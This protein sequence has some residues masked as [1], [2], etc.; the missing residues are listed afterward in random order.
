MAAFIPV[1]Y[2]LKPDIYSISLRIFRDDLLLQ[3]ENIPLTVIPKQFVTQYLKVTAAQNAIR[4]SDR[5]Y[6]DWAAFARGR[7]VTAPIPLWE[8]DFIMP[9]AGKITTEFGLTRYVNNANPTRH[10]GLD[11]A[12][13]KGTPV[14]ATNSGRV[15]LAQ[16]LYVPGNTVIIDHGLN[17]LSNYYHLDKIYV[18]E[19]DEVKKGDIIG[20]VGSTGFSTGPHLHWTMTV[21]TVSVSP[22]QIL[23]KN[24]LEL[25]NLS[26]LQ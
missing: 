26:E 25:L 15:T 8:E 7:A 4:T 13:P 11:I 22:W 18:K 14:K 1:S 21:G 6:D 20:A 19:G 23:E 3:D 17:I 5:Q 10:S 16:S 2:N 24:P 12:A 9:V